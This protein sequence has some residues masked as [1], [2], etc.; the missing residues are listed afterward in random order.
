MVDNIVLKILLFPFSILY[1]AVIGIREI[2]Y[3]TQLLKGVSFDIPIISVG[4]LSVG[5]TGKT[6]HIEYLL[7]ILGPYLNMGALS[8][9]YKRKTS[10]Y[11]L[12]NE[13]DSALESGDEP[14]QIK[15]KFKDVL[16][17]VSENRVFAIPKML[18]DQPA[19]QTI[20]LDDAFQHR[21]IIPGLNILLTEYSKPFFKDFLLPVGT[22]REFP[23]SYKRADIIIITKCPDDLGHETAQNFIKSLRPYSHQ[24]I[25]FSNFSYQKPYFWFNPSFSYPLTEDTNVLLVSAIANS[26]YL[27]QYLRKTVNN[28]E[29]LEFRDHHYFKEEDMQALIN[30]FKSMPGDNKIILTTEKDAGRLELYRSFFIENQLPLLVLPVK[31]NI[32]LGQEAAFATTIKDYLLS[33]KG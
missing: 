14:L 22:L 18:M 26:D 1:G 4:N 13:F 25:F 20:L 3:K 19:L 8:R 24:K 2:F 31:V 32:C 7:S 23:E 29:M 30:L 17:A 21:Q 27:V 6:P 9:G 12:V 11:R 16:V 28:I 15:R 5:G 33:F 10:G